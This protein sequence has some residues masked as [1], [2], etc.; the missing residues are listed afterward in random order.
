VPRDADKRAIKKAYKVR[1]RKKPSLLKKANPHPE[2]L[3]GRRSVRD[4]TP[5]REV[6]LGGWKCSTHALPTA[7]R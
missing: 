3:Q 6:P 5:P 1:S 4:P 7:N 2:K